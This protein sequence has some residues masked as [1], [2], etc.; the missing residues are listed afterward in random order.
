MSPDRDIVRV[1]YKLSELDVFLA[2]TRAWLENTND[3]D[4]LRLCWPSPM[5][6]LPS[7]AIDFTTDGPYCAL[8]S[9]RLI[10][11]AEK[12]YCAGGRVAP[13]F[14]FENETTLVI[15]G[16]QI[17]VVSFVGSTGAR[18]KF[19]G[20]FPDPLNIEARKAVLSAKPQV[21]GLFD[22]AALQSA[23]QGEHIRH[24]ERIRVLKDY[25]EKY[26]W[27]EEEIRK[28]FARTMCADVLKTGDPNVPDRR[29][30]KEFSWSEGDYGLLIHHT[31]QDVLSQRVFVATSLGHY[32]LARED[33]QA[34]DVVVVATGAETPYLLRPTGDGYFGFVGFC[35][36]HGLMNGEAWGR[37][38]LSARVDETP[39]TLKFKII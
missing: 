6:S 11:C 12:L 21:K 30:G 9:A 18:E 37:T 16:I 14:S 22:F 34:G 24:K 25:S 20:D 33:A 8:G 31:L 15:H 27:T 7:W 17:G 5:S 10:G 35:Y 1:D 4:I 23:W 19:W 13:A 32:C 26:P 2:F 28:A 3:L 39:E 29:L 38:G 36:V